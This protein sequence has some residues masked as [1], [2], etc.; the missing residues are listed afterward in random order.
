[1]YSHVSARGPAVP[2][3]IVDSHSHV[4][5]V[6]GTCGTADDVT[7]RAVSTDGE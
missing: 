7:T 3:T 2:L 5:G 1:M 4:S 6:R